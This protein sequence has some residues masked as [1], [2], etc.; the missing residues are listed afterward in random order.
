MSEAKHT[1]GPWTAE[2][3]GRM[4]KLFIDSAA[5]KAGGGA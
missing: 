5:R 2:P 3:I 1:P 4:N